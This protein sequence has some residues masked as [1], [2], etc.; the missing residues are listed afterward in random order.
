MIVGRKITLAAQEELS[1]VSTE[2]EQLCTVKELSAAVRISIRG[3]ISSQDALT[4]PCL[5]AA[6]AQKNVYMQVE[7]L[8]NV[9]EKM[10]ELKQEKA[11]LLQALVER[12][13]RLAEL[14]S[15]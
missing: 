9:E 11:E 2:R 5:A 10:T 1:A 14:S 4:E 6:I 12:E 13:A 3:S 7:R 15:V 8:V